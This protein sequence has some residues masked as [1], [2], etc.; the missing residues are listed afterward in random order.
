MSRRVLLLEPNYKNKFPPIGLMKMATYFR[1]RGDDVVFYKGDLKEFVVN[2]ITDE[3]V[4]KLTEVDDVI[5]WRL[6]SV[7]IADYIRNRKRADLELIGVDDS[8]FAIFIYPWL[9][10]YKKFYHS[11]EYKLHPRWDWVG[12][13][14][15]F[16]FYWKITI[17]T[18]EFAKTMVKDP[19][20]NLM[21]GGVL[22]TI[23]PNE[24]EAATGIRPWCGTLHTPGDIDAGDPR[25]IDELPL[26]YSILDEVD[27]VYPDSGAYYSYATRGCI[28]KCPF[29]A[30]WTLE[31]RYQDYIPLIDR[32]NRTR[33]LYGDQKNLLLMDNNV[34]A[35]KQLEQIVEDIKACGFTKGAKYIEPNQYDIAIRNLRLGMNNRAYVRKCFKLLQGINEYKPLTDEERT[36]IY[37][38]RKENGLLNLRT[39]TREA[40]ITT[41]KDF[42]AYFNKRYTRSRSKG[43]LRHVDFN[44]GVDAR[45][46]N[47]QVVSLLSEIPVR[48]LRIAF[49]DIKTETA[50]THAL[51]MSVKHGIKDFSNYLLYNFK[52][53]PADLY[54]RLRINVDLCE[55]L[56]VS[57]YSFPMKYH[58]IRDEYSHDRNYIGPHWNRKYIRAVQA[59]LNA[60]KGKIG[61]GISF[62]EKA[63]GRNEEEFMELLI[64]PETF[65]LFRL[66][67][68]HLGYTDQWRK[69]MKDLSEE[70]REELMPIIYKNDFN[71]IE[72]LPSNPKLRHILKFYKDYRG[73]IANHESELYLKKEEFN[74][75]LQKT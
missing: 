12:V 48:P 53:K 33:R 8:E 49:D 69:A 59:V 5:D 39:C 3:C 10:H 18:I 71:H 67:F 64:M 43:R 70:E 66:F 37:A 6:R 44:Q 72:E 4:A 28:R 20:H 52:D 29:C 14:T 9:E 38:L 68:E 31:P 46:F 56:G 40:L 17:E 58:P 24:I 65:I 2:Q 50:Y 32:I 15:L 30:V 54:H 19:T 11:G 60:T 34:L 74:K 55:K 16:T 47:E 7:H 63:F 45:L 35:S 75:I 21:V 41:Y 61:R 22:A 26:D 1:L 57:V 13:T 73:D 36:H 42:A 23:Q 25:I 62:F 27:Y 51:T